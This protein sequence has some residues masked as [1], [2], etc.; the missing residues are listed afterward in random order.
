MSV[1][2]GALFTIFGADMPVGVVSGI[3]MALLWAILLTAIVDLVGRYLRGAAVV[4]MVVHAPPLQRVPRLD[5]RAR[6]LLERGPL[7]VVHG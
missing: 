3:T 6:H 4:A 7:H 2:F 5:P 1:Y